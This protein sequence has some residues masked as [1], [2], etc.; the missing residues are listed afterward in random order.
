MLA[1]NRLGSWA[2]LTFFSAL[3]AMCAGSGRPA[4]AASCESLSSLSLPNVKITLATSVAAGAFMPPAAGGIGAGGA[5]AVP[6]F[7]RF[8]CVLPCGGD[9][10][11]IERL[12]YQDRSVAASVRLE[13]QVPS[14]RQWRLG[15]GHQLQRVGARAGGRL[16]HCQHGHRTHGQHRKLC[17]RA[18]GKDDRLCVPLGA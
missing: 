14:C 11:A 12:R 8:A 15:W 16:R 10:D 18:S 6:Q 5:P 1:K 7:G 3:V 2:N 4:N 17:L 9:S 13:R